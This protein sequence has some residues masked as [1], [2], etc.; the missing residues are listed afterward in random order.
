MTWIH[1]AVSNML[2]SIHPSIM[3]EEKRKGLQLEQFR[4]FDFSSMKKELEAIFTNSAQIRLRHVPL[5]Y[6]VGL[7]GARQYPKAP[8]RQFGGVS[9]A[10]AQVFDKLYRE[11]R[12]NRVL[13]GA[14]QAGVLQQ[15]YL[16]GYWPDSSGQ[17]ALQV[18]Y[19]YQVAEVV[20][21]DPMWNGDIQHVD[22]ITLVRTIQNPNAS[23][24]MSQTAMPWCVRFEL[25]PDTAWAVLPDGTQ[26]GIFEPGGG[27][28]L[29]MIPLVMTK[30]AE[31]VERA[32]DPVFPV[33]AQD[34][35]S[36]QI[37]IILVLSDSEAT[38]R[39]QT[40]V[41]VL[42]SGEDAD[43]LPKEMP[44]TA[45]SWLVLPGD[46]KAQPITM[47]P[48]IE[49][50]IRVAETTVYYLS[51]FRYLRP[52]AYQASIVTGAARRA[53]AEGFLEEGLR[54]E[55]RCTVLEEDLIRL[56]VGVEN[57]RPRAL[58]LEVPDLE[59]EFRYV[60]SAE[61]VL[62]EQQALAVK[63]ANLMASQVEEV[64]REENLTTDDARKL[65]V[66]RA[67]DL[68]TYMVSS[69]RGGTPGLDRLASSQGSSPSSGAPAGASAT[70]GQVA[71]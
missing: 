12:V 50:Y 13:L 41:K 16:V 33:C 39:S 2:S 45:G 58:R 44:D 40:R 61:N 54:Q 7:D 57:T 52:E 56:I 19:P 35:L 66:Q 55:G 21:S 67:E 4:N 63:L 46:V 6:R 51:Q 70:D 38:T 5:A 11:R 20:V 1:E 30:R 22:K 29:G 71:P 23:T 26:L 69:M 53:D 34:A 60:K 36:C 10:M 49:K 62:Q 17:P 15:S 47:D 24:P 48:P 25:T 59:V 27:N 42:V 65:L 32:Q 9:S 68:K 28:P 43:S 37:G 64:A 14:E 8:R 18:F 31:P 3:V